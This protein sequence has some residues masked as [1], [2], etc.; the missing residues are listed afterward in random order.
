MATRWFRHNGTG[1]EWEV[2]EGELANRLALNPEYDEI[3]DPTRPESATS[4]VQ[5]P[6]KPLRDWT[7]KE[8]RQF[9]EQR[10]LPVPTGAKKAD[11]VEIVVALLNEGQVG[12]QESG[13]V[14]EGE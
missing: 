6:E 1:H 11:L 4:V 10:G 12:D 8:L 9:A 14:S 7:A 3:P 5:Y 13:E 2:D